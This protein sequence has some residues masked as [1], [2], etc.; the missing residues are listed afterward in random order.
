MG[1]PENLIS[2]LRKQEQRICGAVVSKRITVSFEYQGLHK[3]DEA[4][5]EV[6][7]LRNLH[8]HLF[9][10]TMTVEVGSDREIEFFSLKGRI[11]EF[12]RDTFVEEIDPGS[13]EA[14]AKVIAEAFWQELNTVYLEVTISED[15]ENSGMCIIKL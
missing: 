10:G 14:Q 11:Y 8:R 6:F 2:K 9:K 4:P 3:W 13:C 5:E 7:Y 15:G 12:L 1:Q